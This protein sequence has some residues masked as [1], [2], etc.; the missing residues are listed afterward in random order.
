MNTSVPTRVMIDPGHH[1]HRQTWRCSSIQRSIFCMASMDVC[2]LCICSKNSMSRS[3]S[4]RWPFLRSTA[5]SDADRA[6]VPTRSTS[7]PVKSSCQNSGVPES[8]DGPATTSRPGHVIQMSGIYFQKQAAA[9][10]EV[11]KQMHRACKY[12]WLTLMDCSTGCRLTGMLR[13]QVQTA[14]CFVST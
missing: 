14:C 2:V 11:H 12:C 5:A 8:H 6:R 4:F 13:V 7:D 10:T 3:C 1:W 9:D